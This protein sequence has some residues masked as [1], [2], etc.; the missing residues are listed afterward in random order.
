MCGIAGIINRN[1]MDISPK[2]FGMLS[3]IQHRGPDASG[4]AVYE[5]N[6]PLLL[7][8]SVTNKDMHPSLLRLVQEYATVLSEQSSDWSRHVV[9][10]ELTLEMDDSNVPA[11]HRAVNSMDGLYV[12]SIGKSIRVYK[13]GGTT[14]KLLEN[15]KI[16]AAS[17]TH[18]MGHVRM[19]TESAEDINAAHPFVSPFFSDLSIVHNGQFTNYFNLRR[20][21]ESRGAVFKTYNDSEAASHLIAWAMQQ[22]GGDLEEALHFAL[23]EMDGI[24]CIIAATTNQMGFVKDKMGIKPLLLLEKDGMVL[25]GSE[26]IEFTA[27]YSDVYADEMEPGEVRVWNI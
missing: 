13:D 1:G 12:H 17:A 27:L 14:D 11:L 2:L 9:F 10:S 24:F 21:L 25:M 6:A 5:K 4:V 19:S 22:N 7:R 26:Q 20:S 16:E 3:L 23:E 18:G 15:H 8:T